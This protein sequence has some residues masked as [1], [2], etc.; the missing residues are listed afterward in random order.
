MTKPG[1]DVT[2]TTNLRE[3]FNLIAEFDSAGNGL[4]FDTGFEEIA[5]ETPVKFEG[6]SIE[7]HFAYRIDNL[8]NGWQYAVAVTAFDQGDK[9]RRIQS[10]ESSFL[11]N[12]FRVFPGNQS[13]PVTDEN[14]PFVYPNPYYYGASWEGRS[15]FQEES[16]KLIFS[17]LPQNC[18]IRI[19]FK[20]SQSKHG[21]LARQF[22]YI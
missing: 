21:D 6:D 15:N 3:G 17:N 12:D 14:E 2:G 11:A 4:F 8:N 13:S 22:D 5:L 7:Y 9:E 16:R 10:L 19:P 18:R 1:F 20:S